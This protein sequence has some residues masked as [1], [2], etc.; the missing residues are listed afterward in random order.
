[1]IQTANEPWFIFDEPFMKYH[2]RTPSMR[3]GSVYVLL[4]RK[5]DMIRII[6]ETGKIGWVSSEV[7]VEDD[8]VK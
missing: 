4:E 5:H 3:V 2:G 6:S 8:E 1:M 7:L